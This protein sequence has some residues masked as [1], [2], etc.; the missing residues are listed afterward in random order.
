MADWTKLAKVAGVESKS[1]MPQILDRGRHAADQAGVLRS[2]PLPVLLATLLVRVDPSAERMAIDSSLESGAK[3]IVANML[4]LPPY[5]LTFMLAP[6]YATLP[7]EEDLDAVR[8][9]AARAAALGIP[10]ELLRISS[11]RPVRALLELAR[12][13]EAGLLVFGPHLSMTPRRRF[14]IAARRV[15]RE[16]D[17]LVWIAPDG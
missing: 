17:C 6:E 7:H 10:T 8:A 14:R 11:G 5:P 1:A 16:A 9:T 4:V 2:R 15:R 3:L 12:E 13:R